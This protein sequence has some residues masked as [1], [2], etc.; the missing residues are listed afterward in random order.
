MKAWD[1]YSQLAITCETTLSLISHSYLILESRSGEL[2]Q[3]C[4]AIGLFSERSDSTDRVNPVHESV[5]YLTHTYSIRA[6]PEAWLG[7]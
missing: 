5:L 2:A 7:L 4:G 3:T 6:C 1:D